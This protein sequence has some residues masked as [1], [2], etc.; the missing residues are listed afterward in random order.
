MVHSPLNK[1]QQAT[2]AVSGSKTPQEKIASL[3]KAFELFSQETNRLENAYN[4][5][6]SDFQVVNRELKESNALLANKVAELDSARKYLNSILSNISQGLLFIDLNGRIT[7]FNR[8][9][10]AILRKNSE[11]TLYKSF[12]ESFSDD[13][14]GFSMREALSKH[15]SPSTSYAIM[16]IKGV[17]KRELEVE[18]TFLKERAKASPSLLMEG[19]ILLI[20]DITD[21]RRLQMLANRNDRLKELGEMAAMVAHEIRNPL[22]GIKGFAS[23]LKR[24]L[25]ECPEQ[26]KM[27]DYIIEGTDNLNRLVGAVLNYSRPLQVHLEATNLVELIQELLEHIRADASISPSIHLS[28]TSKI[29]SVT[30]PI[31]SAALKGAL[32]NLIVN[33][34]QAMPSEGGEIN[35][36]VETDN[37]SG[38]IHVID[39]GIGIP[40]ENLEKIFSPFFTTRA[41]G[42][43]FGLA[44][45]YKVVQAHGGTIDVDSTVGKGT[46]FTLKLPLRNT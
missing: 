17:G 8:A 39:T 2:H 3:T 32:L 43:G 4:T 44:E 1:L 36:L 22:G 20:R 9:A 27:A 26:Q 30:I 16:E 41:D 21:L 12:W 45:V 38:I 18:T 29:P 10:A 42:N 25:K 7:T 11:D 5:L 23:L 24:D 15:T 6:K 40:A 34:I 13:L 35:L 28:T 19:M 46:T 33:A 14:F 37:E 31:D